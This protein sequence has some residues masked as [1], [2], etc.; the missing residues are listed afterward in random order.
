MSQPCPHRAQGATTFL[1]KAPSQTFHELFTHQSSS[2][3]RLSLTETCTT[4]HAHTHHFPGGKT[5]V[6]AMSNRGGKPQKV[7]ANYSQLPSGEGGP[8]WIWPAMP[9]GVRFSRL[10]LHGDSR[11]PDFINMKA[12]KIVCHCNII[13]IRTSLI[14]SELEYLTCLQTTCI[15]WFVITHTHPYFYWIVGLFLLIYR[16]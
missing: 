16:K 10:N 2:I 7:F 15:K 13:I 9:T 12:R 1:S 14:L 4:T 5:H 3:T 6:W 11:P 8:T